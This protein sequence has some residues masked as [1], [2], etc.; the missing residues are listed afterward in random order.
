[1][2]SKIFCFLT[3]VTMSGVAPAND[4]IE[5]LEPIDERIKAYKDADKSNEAAKDELVTSGLEKLLS[6]SL[7]LIVANDLS[8]S[9]GKKNTEVYLIDKTSV[10][11][12]PLNSKELIAQKI[13]DKIGEMKRE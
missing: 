2:K 9:L 6:E 4:E 13:W 11:Y 7:D 10:E 3:L 1:M 5:K 8:T 12:L